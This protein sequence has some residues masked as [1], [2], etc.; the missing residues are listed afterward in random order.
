MFN[1]NKTVLD[2]AKRQPL[3]V[4]VVKETK[5][6]LGPYDYGRGAQFAIVCTTASNV[7]WVCKVRVTPTH[8]FCAAQDVASFSID[9]YDEEG[10]SPGM[11]ETVRG[12][13]CPFDSDKV[14]EL[15]NLV[16]L[17]ILTEAEAEDE[18]T[19]RLYLTVVMASAIAEMGIRQGRNLVRGCDR[20][21]VSGTV[22][23]VHPF[24]E[25]DE[26]P[27]NNIRTLLSVLSMLTHT[28]GA[29]GVTAVVSA[30]QRDVNGYNYTCNSICTLHHDGQRALKPYGD[31]F[32]FYNANSHNKVGAYSI[33]LTK[34]TLKPIEEDEWEELEDT[35]YPVVGEIDMVP[36][37]LSILMSYL[38]FIAYGVWYMG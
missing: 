23:N 27:W 2:F 36:N 3:P 20:I 19:V 12:S 7:G 24:L 9:A 6:H 17:G 14:R 31:C 10:W 4:L 1:L 15:P 29:L 38:P 25:M 35:M 21:S 34:E 8:D 16:D 5:S 28:M 33:L 26:L 13:S 32:V 30:L 37:E 22:E 11:V 18:S